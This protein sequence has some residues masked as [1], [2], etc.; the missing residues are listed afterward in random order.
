MNA[1]VMF[2]GLSV[3]LDEKCSLQLLFYRRCTEASWFS[4]LACMGKKSCDNAEYINSLAEH[5]SNSTKLTFLNRLFLWKHAD[6]QFP[7]VIC[8]WR[9]TDLSVQKRAGAVVGYDINNGISMVFTCLM[10]LQ[11]LRVVIKLS[12]GEVTFF[13][14]LRRCRGGV[15]LVGWRLTHVLKT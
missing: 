10:L 11:A 2:T 3:P 5:I 7:K 13:R 9:S 8:R 14:T 4:P 1:I 15:S 12:R 6:T